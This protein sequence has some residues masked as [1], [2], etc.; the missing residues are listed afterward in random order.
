[1][2][3]VDSV[4]RNGVATDAI[5]FLQKL[6][7]PQNLLDRVRQALRHAGRLDPAS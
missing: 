3:P 5:R 4:A 2:A 6:C 7:A 1:M